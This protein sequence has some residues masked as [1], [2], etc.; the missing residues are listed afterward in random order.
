MYPKAEFCILKSCDVVSAVNTCIMSKSMSLAKSNLVLEK[1]SS[2][3]S[4]HTFYIGFDTRVRSC[5]QQ[6]KMQDVTVLWQYFPFKSKP[7]KIIRS[8]TLPQSSK[9][10]T[11]STSQTHQ[12]KSHFQAFLSFSLAL[13][14]QCLK[15]H[16]KC[17]I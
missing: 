17:L 12:T 2:R 5:S 10:S 16:P 1:S 7:A 11:K 8:P 3:T 6:K 13:Y 15:N 9:V 4:T 14:S